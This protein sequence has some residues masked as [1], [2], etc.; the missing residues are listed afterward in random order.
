MF[1]VY[2]MTLYVILYLCGITLCH[3]YRYMYVLFKLAPAWCKVSRKLADGHIDSTQ[4]YLQPFHRHPELT[5]PLWTKIVINILLSFRLS[6]LQRHYFQTKCSITQP[7]LYSWKYGRSV[8]IAFR[9]S[10]WETE[11]PRITFHHFL[12][13]GQE[14]YGKEIQYVIWYIKLET[15]FSF[16]LEFIYLNIPK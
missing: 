15:K 7:N 4:H 9:P 5:P 16:Q 13:I 8:E 14:V 10:C 12:I 3:Q 1:C 2:R 6:Q 11:Q